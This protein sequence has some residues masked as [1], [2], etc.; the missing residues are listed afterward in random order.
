MTEDSHKI[1][2]CEEIQDVLNAIPECLVL[3]DT[4]L[5]ILLTND[6]FQKRFIQKN[7][8]ILDTN[9]LDTFWDDQ[10][11][12]NIQ[13]KIDLKAEKNQKLEARNLL[14]QGSY[15][16]KKTVLN[17][18]DQ[19]FFLFLFKDI[20]EFRKL[21]TENKLTE[22]KL[23]SIVDCSIQGICI[24]QNKDVQFINRSMLKILETNQ[25]ELM[26]QNF[27]HLINDVFNS[28]PSFHLEEAIERSALLQNHENKYQITNRTDGTKWI[29]I[30]A[31]DIIYR[32]EISTLLNIA[33]ITRNEQTE[34]TLLQKEKMATIGQLAAGVAHEIN[35]PLAYIQSN[36]RML[37]DYEKSFQ[38]FFSEITP[39]IQGE[40]G[41]ENI[42]TLKKSIRD[43]L[44]E[45]DIDF[46]LDDMTDIIADNLQ[47]VDQI[48]HIIKDLRKFSMVDD[49][50]K[51][52]ANINEIIKSTIN[53]LW[54]QIKYN[55]LVE[56][57]LDEKIEDMIINAQEIGQCFMN[58]ILNS[59]DAIEK[60]LQ[61]EKESGRNFTG[62]IKT[63]S[64]L[65]GKFVRIDIEDNGCGIL[66]EN[67]KKIYDPFFTTKTIGQGTGLGLSIV[68]DIIQKHQ[69]EISVESVPDKGTV[70]T[71]NLPVKTVEE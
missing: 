36:L 51:R 57:N 62:L 58:L 24:L 59:I 32:Q 28:S 27:E 8:L 34:R 29:Q 42:S 43:K 35:N 71:I 15:L 16:I 19:I 55:S 5:N 9:L 50:E 68:Y 4:D 70:F 54:N 21:Q 38:K 53:V 40:K 14:C 30:W 65:K 61:K 41:I 13:K 69:G 66:P 31:I 67:I 64:A 33:D 49:A 26:N 11:Q 6:Y 60:R 47:G 20:S 2:A 45:I 52:V 63:K 56:Q 46:L 22:W 44:E 18:H 10:G 7:K 17:L 3:T 37:L 1:A 25:E 48:A 39:L 23:H 12:R